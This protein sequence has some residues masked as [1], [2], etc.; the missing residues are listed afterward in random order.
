MRILLDTHVFLWLIAEPDKLSKRAIE[1]IEDS[2]IPIFLSAVS[3]WEIVVKHSKGR[4][5]LSEDPSALIP[6]M[7]T[8][9]QISSL[10]LTEDSAA[11]GYRLP[12]HHQDPFDR[13]LV[14]QAIA[15][16]MAIMTADRA[17][18]QYPIQV[19]W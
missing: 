5:P 16:Q 17:I 13:M 11:I 10:A 2:S 19:V 6:K 12:W 4:L 15:E 7:R 9:Y 1:L 8:I 18:R 14:S 3:V